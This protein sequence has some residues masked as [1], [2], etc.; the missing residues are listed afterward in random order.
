MV[1]EGVPSPEQLPN[2]LEGL[3][4]LCRQVIE[5]LGE[6]GAQILELQA[7]NGD[8][9]RRL[10]GRKSEQLKRDEL[11]GQLLLPELI[12][13]LDAVREPPPAEPPPPAPEGGPS[14]SPESPADDAG[15]EPPRPRRRPRRG[16]LPAQIRRRVVVI[17]LPADE[18]T[19]GCCGGQLVEIGYETSEQLELVPAHL[20]VIERRRMKYAC[21]PCEGEVQVAPAPPDPIAKGM[22]G[23]QL[24]SQVLI[25]KYCDHLPLYRQSKIFGRLGVAIPRSTMCLWVAAS[26]EKLERIV[27]VMRGDVL[28]SKVLRTDDT[29][30]R[31]IANTLSET[32]KGRLWPYIGDEDHPHVVFDYTHSRERDGPARFLEEFKGKYLQADAFSGYDGIYAGSSIIEVGCWA[33]ARRKFYDARTEDPERANVVLT[34]IAGLYRVER[35]A[36]NLDAVMR[37]SMRQT[38][39]QPLLDKL[40][41]LLERYKAEVLPKSRLGKAVR[42]VQNQ[43]QALKRY[44]E[45]GDLS[46]D[47]NLTER[48]VRPVAVGRKNWLFFGSDEGGRRAA[49]LYSLI[50]S[51]QRVGCDPL[52]YL[53]DVLVRVGQCPDDELWGLTPFAWAAEQERRAAAATP[54]PGIASAEAPV[55]AAS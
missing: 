18:R 34:L 5:K 1:I 31:V 32:G 24:L 15:A 7:E 47:N 37:Q 30:V 40:A 25:G 11:M 4:Q 54:A 55:G 23:P 53:A 49:V 33:H 45:D 2:D 20:E 26:A 27:A 50:L 42:Y 14:D 28:K 17:E 48:T 8:L 12:P 13:L 10:F 19:C 44:L 35:A 36:Q 16:S 39:S 22:P 38:R 6:L 43:W 46:I 51:C 41:E 9:R 29:S 21:R 3:R 52:A